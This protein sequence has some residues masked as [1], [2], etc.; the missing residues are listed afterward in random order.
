MNLFLSYDVK[1]Y[2]FSK[3]K[4]LRFKK[5]PGKGEGIREVNTQPCHC[6]EIKIR[7]KINYFDFYR[8]K[9]LFGKSK[10]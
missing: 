1:N 4:N 7:I 6:L 9:I 8:W 3:K 10:Y 2:I 5:T